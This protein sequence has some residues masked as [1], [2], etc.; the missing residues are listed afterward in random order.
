MVRVVFLLP[1]LLAALTG[2][3]SEDPKTRQELAALRT[4]I[5]ELQRK[6]T[7]LEAELKEARDKASRSVFLGRDVLSRN[8]EAVMPELRANLTRA[9]PD[10]KV[11]PVSPGT[12][13]TPL[14]EQGFP[15]N[16]ELNFGISQKNGRGFNSYTINIKADREGRWQMPDLR[17]IAALEDRRSADGGQPTQQRGPAADGPR[18]IDWGEQNTA[19]APAPAP[20]PPPQAGPAA[21]AAPPS[22]PSQPAAQAPFPVQDSRTIQFD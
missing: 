7:R 14:D 1:A 3:E 21:P 19:S 4:E 2:C 15:Y 9:F 16:T 22:R 8:L 20:A 10:R 5:G 11:D 13:S 12:I 18:I 17:T 6:N